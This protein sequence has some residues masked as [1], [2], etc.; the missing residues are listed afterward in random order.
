MNHRPV[1][2]QC[3]QTMRCAKNEVTAIQLDA[4]ED[5]ALY[6]SDKYACPGCGHEVLVG[7]GQ[8]IATRYDQHWRVHVETKDTVRFSE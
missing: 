5:Y 8:T 2:V 1:C 6:S 4:G 3:K 7:F